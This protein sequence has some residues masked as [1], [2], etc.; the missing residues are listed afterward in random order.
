[1]TFNDELY[2]RL[3]KKDTNGFWKSWHKHFHM[4]NLKPTCTLNRKHGEANVRNKFTQHYKN[5]YTPNNTCHETV[6]K[7]Q[8]DTI[9]ESSSASSETIPFFRSTLPC[10]LC[11]AA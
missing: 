10:L 3:C 11:Q 1:M 8:V 9:L 6:Y 5:V 4:K 7:N 2:D